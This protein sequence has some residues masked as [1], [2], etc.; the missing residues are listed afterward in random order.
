MRDKT[1]DPYFL[2]QKKI[3]QKF[4]QLYPE[5]WVPLYSMV[6]FSNISYSDAWNIGMK[7]EDIMSQIMKTPDIH[8]IWDSNDIMKKMQKM[9]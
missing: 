6:S 4:S 2:L 1:A 5:K 3:E 7:Q 8:D 9:L